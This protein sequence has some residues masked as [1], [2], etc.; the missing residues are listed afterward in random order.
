L[1]DAGVIVRDVRRYPML[2]DAL[3]ITLGSPDQNDRVLAVLRSL[4]SARTVSLP[5]ARAGLPA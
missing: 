2:G 1:R 4:D 5:A 3:R